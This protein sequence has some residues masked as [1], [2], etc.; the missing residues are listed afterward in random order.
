MPQCEQVCFEGDDG[1]QYYCVREAGHRGACKVDLGISVDVTSSMR[2]I[3]YD[4]GVKAERERCDGIV[5]AALPRLNQDAL[6]IARMILTAIRSGKPLDELCD[7]NFML[8]EAK[9]AE[10]KS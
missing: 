3:G 7:D 8:L 1:A 10:G 6:R 5:L 2:M 4:A 9:P